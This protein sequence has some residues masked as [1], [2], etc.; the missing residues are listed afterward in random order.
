MKTARSLTSLFAPAVLA[1]GIAWGLA[2]QPSY[3]QTAPATA[4]TASAAQSTQADVTWGDVRFKK[5]FVTVNGARLNVLTAGQG[6]AVVLLHG[7]PQS[8][9]IW[10]Y[11]APELAKKYTV[12]VPDLRGYGESEITAGGYDMLNVGKDIRELVRHFGFSKAKVVGHDWGGAAGYAYAAQ[13]RDEVTKLAFME[14]ALVGAGFEQL[15]NFA[16]PNPGFTFLPFLLMGDITQELMLGK[17]EAY[18]RHLWNMFTGDKQALPFSDWQPYVTA[19]KR[20]QGAIGGA[21][22][23]R[24][25]Y[26][27]MPQIKKLNE[28]KLSIPVLSIG[29]EKSIGVNQEAFVRAFASNVSKVLVLQG[30]GHFVAEERPAEVNQALREFLAQ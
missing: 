24:A 1:V 6:E 17:E 27:S 5:Q 20:P 11:V 7:Y 15:W 9:H 13:Y 4:M 29:G 2:S 10:R 16:A 23:Y 21:Q 18:L 14:S 30:A 28:T 8:G 22:Y 25:A 12:I 19:M 26:E 3:A